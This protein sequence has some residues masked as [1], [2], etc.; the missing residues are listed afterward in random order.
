M[1]T[2]TGMIYRRM[3]GRSNLLMD[4]KAMDEVMGYRWIDYRDLDKCE[5]K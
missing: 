5:D 2:W 3:N 1:I 4:A